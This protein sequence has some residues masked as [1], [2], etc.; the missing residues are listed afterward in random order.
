L[1]GLKTLNTLPKN[2]DNPLEE[3]EEDLD[4]SCLLIVT[5]A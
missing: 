1:R 5:A 4:C 2:P 3:Y